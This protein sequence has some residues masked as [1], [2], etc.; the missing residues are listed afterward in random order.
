MQ[1]LAQEAKEAEQRTLEAKIL[2]S[3]ELMAAVMEGNSA[4]AAQ[5]RVA[6]QAEAEQE[7]RIMEYQRLR[8]L[9]EQVVQ[10]MLSCQI[11][12]GL[13]FAASRCISMLGMAGLDG[14]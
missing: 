14:P 10:C 4:L 5:K 13:L 12:C 2:A 9:R 8:D 1:Q 7:R 11:T 3:R 6:E